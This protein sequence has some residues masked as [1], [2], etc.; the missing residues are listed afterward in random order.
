MDATQAQQLLAQVQQL[1]N[2]MAVQ[3]QQFDAE[4]AQRAGEY[5]QLLQQQ[6]QIT[7]SLLEQQA[8]RQG[9]VDNKGIG[10]PNSFNSDKK[11]W[12]SWSFR[13][14]NFLENLRPGMKK[15]LDW[16]QEE[17]AEIGDDINN[18]DMVSMVAASPLIPAQEVQNIS[19][20]LYSVLAQLC[21]G[22][23]SDIVRNVDG[24]NGFEAW[25]LISR[26]YDPAGSGRR[27][28]VLS[29]ILK[30]GDFSL[31]DLTSAISK[32]ET[33]V[34]QYD[35]RAQAQGDQGLPDDVLSSILVEM[36]RG[37]LKEHLELN[38]ARLNNYEV[39]KK[40]IE[41]YVEKKAEK[42]DDKMDLS[43]FDASNIVCRNCN[44]KGHVKKDCWAPGGGARTA[45]GNPSG[46]KAKDGGKSAGKGGKKGDKGGKKGG[47]K[48]DPVPKGGA[49]FQGYCSKCYKWGHKAAECRSSGPSGG[50]GANSLEQAMQQLA[51]VQTTVAAMAAT[52][53]AQ[54]PAGRQVSG[55]TTDVGSLALGGLA[56]CGLELAGLE[57]SFERLEATVDSGAA[58]TAIPL[59]LFGAYL[60]LQ[61][62]SVVF[63]AAGGHTVPSHGRATVG[64][65]TE[66][67]TYREISGELAA[68]RKLLISVYRLVQAGHD[69]HFTKERA[70]I[71]HRVT[72]E[73]IELEEKN[74]VYVM[75]IFDASSFRRQGGCP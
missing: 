63:N 57:E 71:H 59:E 3:R 47:K 72:G 18:V 8:R 51:E 50:K 58:D 60:D 21:D 10:K 75:P 6:Q 14:A 13:L 15:A 61:K 56:L 38:Y 17:A 66:S 24:Q 44:K 68:V 11:S 5:Q 31:E 62:S 20:Q 52:S 27:R 73:D 4:R 2:D 26:K 36:T 54:P 34:R 69:V 74:G 55:G 41:A 7:T 64:I 39:V 9:L 30:P 1:T 19:S 46:G 37:K 25:R 65:L 28:T 22:E 33:R 43:Q 53:S 49:G 35:R 29:N 45:G 12:S 23:S 70:W 16:A 32:W 40:E 48:G 67:G 42:D